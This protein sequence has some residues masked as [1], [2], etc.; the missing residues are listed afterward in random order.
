MGG[1]SNGLYFSARPKSPL[2]YPLVDVD[3]DIESERKLGTKG[4]MKDW[5]P[6]APSLSL[7]NPKF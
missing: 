2:I 6:P 3:F 5:S 7:N 4:F 1:G